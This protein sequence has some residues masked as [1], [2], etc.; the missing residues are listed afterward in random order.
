MQASIE[1]DGGGIVA[2]WFIDQLGEHGKVEQ[3]TAPGACLVV[4]LRKLRAELMLQG[5]DVLRGVGH[6]SRGELGAL[7]LGAGV[8]HD[9]FGVGVAA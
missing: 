8:V 9:L 3:L 5:C 1:Q 6:T 7:V 2:V 4:A